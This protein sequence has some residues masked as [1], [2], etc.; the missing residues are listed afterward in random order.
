MRNWLASLLLVGAITGEVRAQIPDLPKIGR[1]WTDVSYPKLFW[2][3]KDGFTAGLYYAQIR[4][5]GFL[6]FFEPQPYGGSLEIDGQ[7]STSGSKLLVLEAR[8]PRLVEG[9]RFAATAK[10]SR[11]ARAYYFGLGNQTAYDGTLENDQQPLYYRWNHKSAFLRAEAQRQI[12]GGLRALVGVHLERSRTDTVA[13]LS[14]L[15]QNFAA[16]PSLEVERAVAQLGVR[17]GLVF[18]TRNDEVAPA[19]G[20]LL[21]GIHSRFGGESRFHRTTLSGAAYV[22][23][24]GR[25]TFAGR[26]VAQIAGGDPPLQALDVVEVSENVYAGVGGER[27]HRA[28]LERRFLGADKL[29]FNADIRWE[30]ITTPT[31]YR[32]TLL[33]FLDAGR[34]F[35]QDGLRLT[36]EGLHVGAGGGIMLHFFRAAVMGATVGFGEDGGTLTIHTQWSY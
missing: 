15:A 21:E 10:V 28:F 33:T 13:G 31:L 36:A 32:V 35:D 19:R 27:S 20:V 8:L 30:A 23:P 14:L 22:T 12:V 7:V 29:L 18:D 6:N 2:T 3:S 5:M 11:E 34:V 24:F 26:V 17:I 16:D 4:P 9:W 25:V 1:N